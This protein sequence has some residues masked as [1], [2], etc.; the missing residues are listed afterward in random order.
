[1]NYGSGGKELSAFTSVAGSVLI[2]IGVTFV[3]W[4]WTVLRERREAERRQRIR[5]GESGHTASASRNGASRELKLL[6][7]DAAL[8]RYSNTKKKQTHIQKKKKT[9]KRSVK[10]TGKPSS[11]SQEKI[12]KKKV[13]LKDND[14]IDEG[15]SEENTRQATLGE[16][17]VWRED[18]A[19]CEQFNG[20]SIYGHGFPTDANTCVE[21]DPSSSTSESTSN[22]PRFSFDG[23]HK[24]SEIQNLPGSNISL[25]L[26]NRLSE[27]FEPVVKAR[28]WN[29][30]QLNEFCC[31]TN[32]TKPRNVAGYCIPAGNSR[33][34]LQICIRLRPHG[35]CG[36]AIFL[37]YESLA[38]TMAHELAHIVHAQHT[39][40]FFK[41]MD[42]LL[43]EKYALG[44]VGDS[45]GRDPFSTLSSGRVLGTDTGPSP[46]LGSR[47]LRQRVA[48]AATKR[49]KRQG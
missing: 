30:L 19:S 8:A 37:P 41:L 13:K 28:G 6:A 15:M 46:V 35:T 14:D 1:M 31:C 5:A 47:E 39:D 23:I 7:A 2:L 22:L 27:D 17:V 21:C 3:E 38:K 33:T 36:S 29:V 48:K 4:K 42:E 24:T 40:D 12:S 11:T 26:L 10:S 44:S 32:N 49:Q 16:H 18:Q 45:N 43:Q 20:F 34:A 25:N 9:K